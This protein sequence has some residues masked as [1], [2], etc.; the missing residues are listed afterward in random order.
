MTYDEFKYLAENPAQY[1]GQSVFRIDTY[2]YYP[3]E[4]I[5]TE[6]PYYLMLG[7]S[8]FH[9]SID[10]VESSFYRI[11]SELLGRGMNIYCHF[12]Y[13]M[14]IRIDMRMEK[15]ISV[16]VYD[17]CGNLTEQSVCSYNLVDS[18]DTEAFRGRRQSMAK[19][20]IGDFVEILSLCGDD[21]SAAVRTALITDVPKSIDDCWGL[22]NKLPNGF[23]LEWIDDYYRYVDE[24]K[25]KMWSDEAH[26]IFVFKPRFHISD[27]RKQELIVCSQDGSVLRSSYWRE[28]GSEK[29]MIVCRVA[30]IDK[31]YHPSGPSLEPAD[32]L[33]FYAAKEYFDA[34]IAVECSTSNPLDAL[35]A[36][37]LELRPDIFEHF[38]G[39]IINFIDSDIKNIK[40]RWPDQSKWWK[41]L[42]Q[43]YPNLGK[44]NRVKRGAKARSGAMEYRLEIIAYK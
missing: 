28:N 27:E 12:A 38:T 1:D 37:L 13:E 9:L 25:Y 33:P 41:T 19:H 24:P 34:S 29:D 7:H 32:F 16:R 23:Y 5:G 17:E 14:P 15:Y 10:D 4:R 35:T 42:K 36:M 3:E 44:M 39:F 30:A 26:P 11:K 18:P 20:K 8:S 40:F 31:Q 22:S 43:K 21:S 2:C 6:E